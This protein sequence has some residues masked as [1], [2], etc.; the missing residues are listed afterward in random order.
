[1]CSVN[2]IFDGLIFSLSLSWDIIDEA[3][4]TITAYLG[5]MISS[6]TLSRENSDVL[7]ASLTPF[8]AG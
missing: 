4:G 6:P 8:L 1:M 7:R 2:A 5:R 3:Y